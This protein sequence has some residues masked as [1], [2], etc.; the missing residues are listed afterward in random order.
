MG[1]DQETRSEG[2]APGSTMAS[3]EALEDLPEELRNAIVEL[4]NAVQHLP[5]RVL[6]WTRINDGA[7]GFGYWSED[8]GYAPVKAVWRLAIRTT[9][10]HENAPRYENQ[11][12]WAFDEVPRPL[13]LRAAGKIHNLIEA[14][15]AEV[16]TGIAEHTTSTENPP[17]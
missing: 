4:E 8:V 5:S 7:D 16:N 12:I 1:A 9:D 3:L 15:A 13:R 6:C 11:E 10:G 14:L 17:T 2:V